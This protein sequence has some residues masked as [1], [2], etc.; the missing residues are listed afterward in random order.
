[1]FLATTSPDCR[2]GACA[3]T[4][5]E[6]GNGG[7]G[8]AKRMYKTG[9]AVSEGSLVIWKKYHV[10]W[11][12]VANVMVHVCVGAPSP[13]GGGPCEGLINGSISGTQDVWQQYYLAW[14]NSGDIKEF[15]TLR[16]DTDQSHCSWQPS[17]AITASQAPDTVVI[18]G[19]AVRPDLGDRLWFDDLGTP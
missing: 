3:Y 4:G 1:M 16:D 18:T 15:C 2:S 17:S 11:R 8:N 13:S 14:R 12:G 19:S 5:T 9:T 7:L 6:M 10:G